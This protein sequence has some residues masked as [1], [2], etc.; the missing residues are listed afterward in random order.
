MSQPWLSIV[1]PVHNGECW[2]EVTL[3]SLV[4]Q[5]DRD[6][7]CVIIDSS[8]KDASLKII[9][10]FARD[11][12]ISV[13]HRPD[14]LPWPEK[15]NL[16]VSM[17]R[18]NYI[19]MLHQD[20]LWLPNRTRELRLQTKA[21]PDAVMLLFPS[22]I[23]D[24]RRRALGVWRCPLPSD[25]DTIPPELLIERLFVQNFI[26]LPAPVIRRDAYL[27]VAGMDASLWYT[28]DW[29]LYLKLALAGP[30]AY[31]EEPTT[32]FRIHGDSLTMK[33]SRST[34]EFRAQMETV[35][36]RYSDCIP[37]KN[38]THVLRVARA[39]IEV[40][41]ALA[42]A[43]NGKFSELSPALIAVARLGPAGL[44]RYL[45]DS[46]LIERVAPRLQARLAGAL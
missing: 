39:S 31:R 9:E 25:S 45:R 5:E 34:A 2:L 29:D 41:T 36:D 42:A 12:T 11:L 28:A 40:N 35:L 46:R 16:A 15:T 27:A 24:S 18:A 32:C 19:A 23:V 4:E 33:G 3:R 30:V 1:M 38:R 8:A 13:H 43:N 44:W 14:V 22:L 17:A 20:D 6:F 7:E 37:S 10:H 21:F 26:A